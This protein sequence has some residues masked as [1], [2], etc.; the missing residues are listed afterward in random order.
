MCIRDRARRD[1]AAAIAYSRQAPPTDP[2]QAAALRRAQIGWALDQATA[3]LRDGDA[4]AARALIVDLLAVTADDALIHDILDVR[5][6]LA[7]IRAS[8]AAKP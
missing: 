2:A 8:L 3:A 4:A 5:P 7:D 1:F 6:E